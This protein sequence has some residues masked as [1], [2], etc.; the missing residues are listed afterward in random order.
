MHAYA[1][2]LFKLEGKTAL[3]TGATKGIGLACAEALAAAGAKVILTDLE[4]EAPVEVAAELAKLGL[5]IVGENLDV[6]DHARQATLIEKYE[7]DILVCN[8]GVAIDPATNEFDEEAAAALSSMFDIHVRSVAQLT[9]LACRRMKSGGSIILMSSLSALRGNTNIGLYGITKAALAQLARNIAVQWG[10][11]N[12]RAN[13]IAP[14]V[15]DTTFATALT[16]DQNRAERRLLQ[17]PLRKWGHVDN[18]A[19]TVVY[20]AS[21]AGSFTTG[22]T[23]VVDGGTL[24]HD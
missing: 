18:I 19:G 22:Q 2:Y 20:L 13:A 4:R 10:P 21:E 1:E 16:Q 23:I 11:K 9:D 14:G 3:V 12:I 17:T 24:I 15:I 6:T 7:P 8:A 5:D